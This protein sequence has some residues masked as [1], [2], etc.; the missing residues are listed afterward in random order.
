MQINK[1]FGLYRRIFNFIIRILSGFFWVL[2]LFAFDEGGSGILTVC[3]AVIHELGHC[4]AHFLIGAG[5][6][7]PHASLCGFGLL[8]R[9]LL[10]YKEEIFVAAGGPLANLIAFLLLLPIFSLERGRLFAFINLLCAASNL[11]PVKNY[12]GYRILSSGFT[13][14]GIERASDIAD[15]ISFALT[16]ATVLVSLYAIYFFDAG[17]WI[18]GIF[19]IFLLKEVD[20]SLKQRF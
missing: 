4:A 5:S 6:T 14:I 7:L 12:D 15:A 8:P 18:F 2:M 16:V 17:Y 19:F 11:L 10:S 1:N 20:V 13:L 3:A 9:R